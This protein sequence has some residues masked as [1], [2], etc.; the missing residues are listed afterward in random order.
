[1]IKQMAQSI[2]NPPKQI[3]NKHTYTYTRTDIHPPLH[4]ER[5][6]NKTHHGS[7]LK[8]D[9]FDFM[10]IIFGFIMHQFKKNSNISNQNLHLFSFAKRFEFYIHK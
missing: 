7:G 9:L 10:P 2:K 6:A 5:K 1:M 4:T 8:I 3:N